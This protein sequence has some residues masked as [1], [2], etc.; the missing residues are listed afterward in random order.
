MASASEGLQ[1]AQ[2]LLPQSRVRRGRG[3]GKVV[4]K[5]LPLITQALR[6]NARTS[7]L[8]SSRKGS[9][10]CKLSSQGARPRCDDF[11]SPQMISSNIYALDYIRI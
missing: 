3:R 6:L 9:S 4:S 11:L 7:S 10:N 2:Q 8:K 1:A 5:E